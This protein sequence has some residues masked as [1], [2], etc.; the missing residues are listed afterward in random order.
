[1]DALLQRVEVE[2]R[3]RRDDDLAVEHAAGGRRRCSACAS[4]GK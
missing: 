1:M 3:G 2:P 4:S